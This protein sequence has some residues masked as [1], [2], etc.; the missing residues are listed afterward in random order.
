MRGTV[1]FYSEEKGY[2][3]VVR[4]DGQKD[5]FFHVYQLQAAGLQ[6]IAAGDVIEFDIAPGRSGKFEAVGISLVRKASNPGGARPVARAAPADAGF[7]DMAER[8]NTHWRR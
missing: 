5:V 3:F 7:R 4:D 2:G 1:K 6:N 8:L